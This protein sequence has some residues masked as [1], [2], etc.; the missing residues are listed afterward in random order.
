MYHSQRSKQEGLHLFL[1]SVV[2]RDKGKHAI[3]PGRPMHADMSSSVLCSDQDR[4]QE[5]GCIQAASHSQ[6]F[7]GRLTW[8]K[9]R[10]LKH[11]LFFF[12]SFSPSLFLFL[13][14]LFFISLPAC[15]SACLSWSP[16]LQNCC[17]LEL[18]IQEWHQPQIPNDALGDRSRF[19]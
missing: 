4:G 9:G 6:P 12:L 14:L 16:V 1:C 18:N 17:S 13:S 19:F 11:F 3:P 10:A 5:N 8:G 2:L 7:H 15:L